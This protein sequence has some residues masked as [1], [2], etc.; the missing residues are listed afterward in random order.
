MKARDMGAALAVVTLCVA[1]ASHASTITLGNVITSPTNFNGFEAGPDPDSANTYV[2]GGI[3]VRYIGTFEPSA[4]GVDPSP[5]GGIRTSWTNE[6]GGQGA[7][8]WY[9]PGVGYTEIA[10]E[11]GASISAIQFLAGSGWGLTNSF[12]QYQLLND[13]SLV[14]SGVVPI[15]SGNCSTG[16]WLIGVA[17]PNGAMAYFGFAG[18]DFDEVRLQN[19][20]F[21]S[22]FFGDTNF[23]AAA[24]DSIAIGSG[25]TAV[26]PEPTSV[27]LM[28][29]GLAF[30]ILHLRRR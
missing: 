8:G 6:I 19:Q 10:L 28:L 2:E 25:E 29:P 5:L 27:V 22:A 12:M 20:G 7:F 15:T 1:D 9:G 17:C 24:I 16:A 18:G 3:R 21:P 11:S 26:V 23:E 4:R 30:L 13:G 14:S